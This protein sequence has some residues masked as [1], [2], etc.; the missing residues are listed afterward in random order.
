M[1]H[2]ELLESRDTPAGSAYMVGPDLHVVGDSLANVITLNLSDLSAVPVVIDG[3]PLGTFDASGGK[4]VVSGGSGSDTLDLSGDSAGRLYRIN[5]ASKGLIDGLHAFEAIESIAAGIGDDVFHFTGNLA[6]TTG[7][8][9]GGDGTDTLT[10]AGR[11]L[12]VRVNL[13][14]GTAASIGGISQIENVTGGSGN[15]IL[16]GDGNANVL[17]GGAGGN[18]ILTGGAGDDTL[19]GGVG[20][21]ILIGGDGADSLE[22]GTGEDILVGGY[23]T[24]DTNISALTAIQFEWTRAGVLYATRVGRINGTLTGGLNGS[25]KLNAATVFDD[26]ESDTL[27][28]GDGQNWFLGSLD[29]ATDQASDEILTVI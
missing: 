29:D 11:A 23:T 12:A 24:Y 3:V 22:G 10:Y 26:G 20:L 2:V 28:G 7:I 6:S 14:A 5:T 17:D 1:L 21:D 25:F 9:T 27:V 13:I 16:F 18:D 4:V 19:F 8:L 15:D